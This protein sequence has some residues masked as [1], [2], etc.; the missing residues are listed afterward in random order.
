MGSRE[1]K[2]QT[3]VSL[4]ALPAFFKDFAERLEQ[5]IS[6]KNENQQNDLTDFSKIRIRVKREG[7]HADVKMKIKWQE[8]AREETDEGDSA[9]EKP[10]KTKYKTLK[11]R[12]EKTFKAMAKE[13]KHGVVPSLD[14]VE[15][16]LEDAAKM[17][18]YPDKGEP[19]YSDFQKA[20]LEFK[21]VYKSKDVAAI[22]DSYA[23]MDKLKDTCHDRYK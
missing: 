13:L 21:K 23:H 10:R 9:L 8:T 12:M 19:F 2:T 15:T 20:C 6:D 7:D 17:V 4:D 14:T 18:T 16:Y 1:S 3:S 11:K 22:K 5:A